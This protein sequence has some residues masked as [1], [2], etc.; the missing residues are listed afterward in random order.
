[1]DEI[2]NQYGES[3]LKKIYHVWWLREQMLALCVRD[4]LLRFQGTDTEKEILQADEP[5]IVDRGDTRS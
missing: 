1:M 3:P 4:F 2:D 5:I